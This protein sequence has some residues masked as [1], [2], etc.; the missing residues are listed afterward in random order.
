M[1][2][3]ETLQFAATVSGT[4]NRAIQWSLSSGNSTAA[5]QSAS[6]SNL[7]TINQDGLYSAPPALTSN[8]AVQIIAMSVADPSQNTAAS[9]TVTPA[10]TFAP[11]NPHYG[12]GIQFDVLSNV[13]VAQGD[14]DYRFRAAASGAVRSF[15]WYD[16]YVRGGDTADCSGTG[17]ECDG[18]GCGT[19]GALQ[20]CLYPDDGTMDH[21]PTDPL[22]QQSTGLQTPPLACVSPSNLRTG[23]VVRTETFS[24]PAPL[25]QGT[26]Y[27]LHWHNSDPNPAANFVSVD[28]DCVWH[29]TI[30]RQPTVPDTDLAVTTIYD[31][32]QK[33]VVNPVAT[34][35]PIFQLNYANG[36]TQGQ[37]YIDSWNVAAA[38]ISGADKVRESFTVSG[39][40]R[41]VTG[42]S[43]RVN[44]VSGTSPLMVTLSTSAGNVIEQGE[45]PASQ[46]PIGEAL[47]SVAAT[48][49]NVTPAWGS[50]TF[51]SP[52]VLAQG[53]TYQLVLSA[54]SDTVYQDYEIEKGIAYNF[55]T[56]TYFGDGYGQFSSNDGNS[57][58]GFMQ[59]GGATNSSNADIQFFFTTQ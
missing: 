2:A 47:T 37:G 39:P 35:T 26:L 25:V 13:Q 49:E 18:Y 41:A 11:A 48:S 51:S 19:G 6:S 15:I 59:P 36:A 42:V 7:G 24:T 16:V 57:W 50:F 46:F 17:C 14:V 27:H 55:S 40:D 5:S 8:V 32:G 21:L 10:G 33:V 38:D 3:G 43:V 54:P 34:D 31:N 44:R 53:Q 12:T 4:P 56:S 20:I 45:I 52:A 9:I 28:D 1:A 30:P 58:T 22:T 29:P 23:A